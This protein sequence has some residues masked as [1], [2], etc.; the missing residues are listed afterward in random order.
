MADP[1]IEAISCEQG[2][3]ALP[4]LA[5]IGDPLEGSRM[6]GQKADGG[7]IIGG[8]AWLVLV[9]GPRVDG[10]TVR[11]RLGHG[12]G[13]DPLLTQLGLEGPLAT[14]ACPVARFHPLGGE[15]LVIEDAEVCQTLD[16]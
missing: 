2:V 4:S 16:G 5:G 6:A 15:R 1:R 8:G 14:W 13:I 9:P 7:S 3:G 10:S 12:V 11:Q